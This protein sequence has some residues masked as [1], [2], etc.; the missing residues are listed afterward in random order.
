MYHSN[1]LYVLFTEFMWSLTLEF[2]YRCTIEFVSS[3]TS[4][5]IWRIITELIWCYFPDFLWFSTYGSNFLTV[6]KDEMNQYTAVISWYYNTSLRYWRCFMFLLWRNNSEFISVHFL[7][8]ILHHF[9]YYDFVLLLFLFDVLFL[10]WKIHTD[11]DGY[12]LIGL[13]TSSQLLGS[14][15]PTWRHLVCLL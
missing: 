4:D 3:T 11:P 2:S 10:C 7:L 15:K 9:P 8:M 1:L 6:C 5:L 13:L 12:L 14:F